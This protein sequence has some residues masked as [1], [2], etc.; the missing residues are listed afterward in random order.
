MIKG[1]GLSETKDYISEYDK[2]VEKTTW[3]I[4][5][6]DSDIFDLVGGNVLNRLS[7]MTEVVRFGLKG[8]ANFKDNS[9]NEITFH[10][11]NRIIGAVTYKIV[12]DSIMKVIPPEI[13]YEL[14]N[15]IIKLS[16]LSE[17]EIK[18]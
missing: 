9:G 12:A 3:K 8:F 18:N 11:T 1:L 2:G 7:A 4:G 15:E 5:V 10:T 17:Q 16:Q 13:K 6:L 14:A